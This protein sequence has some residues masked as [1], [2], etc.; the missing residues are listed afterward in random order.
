VDEVL[1]VGDQEFQDKCIG[2]MK[3]V[4]GQGRTVLFVSHNLAAVKSLCTRGLLLKNGRK[5]FE[6]ETLD[7]LEKYME[8]DNQIAEDGKINREIEKDYKAIITHVSIT[9]SKGQINQEVFYDDEI[10]I[11]LTIESMIE[12]KVLLD[13]TFNTKEGVSVVYAVNSFDKT[14]L[15]LKR[16]T[17]DFQ[18]RLKNN[19]LPG[20]YYL[21]SGV[22]DVKGSTIDYLE[23][24]TS[25]TVLNVAKQS[26][27]SYPFNWVNAYTKT[28]GLWLKTK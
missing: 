13:F 4:S 16:G 27:D 28:N 11:N 20:K 25:F 21:N 1:A 15:M 23:N 9:D 12:D 14:E 6:G 26:E 24:L 2:K 5:I 7:T 18:V 10:V 22:H 3:D 19:F 17:N 8:K